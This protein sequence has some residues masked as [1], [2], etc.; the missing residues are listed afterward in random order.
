MVLRVLLP[1]PPSLSPFLALDYVSICVLSTMRI[2]IDYFFVFVFVYKAIS[3]SSG[4]TAIALT[5]VAVATVVAK[6]L[7]IKP[8]YHYLIPN[9]NAI[10]LAFVVPQVYYPIAMYVPSRLTHHH[11]YY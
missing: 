3:A 5:I 1:G 6:H 11:Y 4:Y 10:G 9:W 7:W 8:K 2:H